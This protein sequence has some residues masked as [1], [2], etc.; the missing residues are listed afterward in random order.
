MI[1]AF[2]VVVQSLRLFDWL[3]VPVT[4]CPN[5]QFTHLV[6]Y[7]QVKGLFIEIIPNNPD[8][9]TPLVVE[10]DYLVEIQ[11]GTLRFQGFELLF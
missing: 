3:M 6:N 9:I 8:I 2:N 7:F 10:N 4:G 5:Y 11:L 1:G